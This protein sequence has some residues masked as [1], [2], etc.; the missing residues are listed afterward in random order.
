MEQN[1]KKYLELIR[2]ITR[3]LGFLVPLTTLCIG[4]FFIPEIRELLCGGIIGA[5]GTAAIFY[6]EGKT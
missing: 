6:Y 3:A 4:I 1:E 5:L 2:V